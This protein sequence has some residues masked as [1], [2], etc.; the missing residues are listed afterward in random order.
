MSIKDQQDIID[1]QR[2]VEELKLRLDAAVQRIATLESRVPDEIAQ[3][4][5]LRLKRRAG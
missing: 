5:T 2:E 1:L 4:E 3:R